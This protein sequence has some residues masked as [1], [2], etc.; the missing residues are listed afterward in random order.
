MQGPQHLPSCTRKGSASPETI[1]LYL[2][3]G[4]LRSSEASN[5]ASSTWFSLSPPTRGLGS[6]LE[7]PHKQHLHGL[8]R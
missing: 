5:R 2:A 8:E 1:R 7:E 6:V 3:Q 4:R